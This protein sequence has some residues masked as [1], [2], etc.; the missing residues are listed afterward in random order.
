MPLTR[1]PLSQSNPTD[2]TPFQKRKST[3]SY[4]SIRNLSGNN[5]GV[6]IKI[7]E[8]GEG[9]TAVVATITHPLQQMKIPALLLHYNPVAIL[10]KLHVEEY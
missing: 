1:L 2:H 5:V 3:D 10:V 4:Q 8:K 9:T 6:L 7:A